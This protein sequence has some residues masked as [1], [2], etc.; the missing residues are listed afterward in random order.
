MRR[1]S[2]TA[3]AFHEL[4]PARAAAVEAFV[5]RIAGIV[6][7]SRAGIR[8]PDWSGAGSASTSAS[9]PSRSSAPS[10]AT[11]WVTSASRL[12]GRLDVLV[13]QFDVGADTIAIAARDALARSRA[14]PERRALRS[15]LGHLP[16][17]GAPPA[18]GPRRPDRAGRGL[19]RPRA[20]RSSARDPPPARRTRTASTDGQ[21]A[22]GI[23]DQERRAGSESPPSSAGRAGPARRWRPRSSRTSSAS[24][25]I[26]SISARS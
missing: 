20:R 24:T 22:L 23:R 10:G 6:V 16:L 9:R 7:A 17:A 26:A 19:G 11:R 1:C 14:E 4:E 25:S 5:D 12:D 2:S 15:A 3:G 8:C 18:R 13:G 21:R